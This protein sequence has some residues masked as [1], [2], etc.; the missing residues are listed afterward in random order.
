KP[1]TK[2]RNIKRIGRGGKRG[3][4]SG[5]GIKGQKSRAG[6]K[7]RPQ[8]RDIIKKLPKK[9]GYS[10]PS[11]KEKPVVVNLDVIEKNFKAGEKVSP[12]TLAEKGIIKRREV[13]VKILGKGEITK[14]IIIENC[15]ISKSAKAKIDK[16]VLE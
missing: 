11:L 3:G 1:K 5:R 8:W 6:R 14:K 16:Y 10:S 2:K 4:Y 9:R 7:I 12:Q 13:K 15:L